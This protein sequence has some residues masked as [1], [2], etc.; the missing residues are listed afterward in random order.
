MSCEI[1]F[2]YYSFFSVGCLEVEGGR[3]E[4]RGGGL[5]GGP[6]DIYWGVG[7]GWILMAGGKDGCWSG[8]RIDGGSGVLRNIDGAFLVGGGGGDGI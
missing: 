4:G 8:G 6:G 5:G 1:S 3:V 7:G 2:S